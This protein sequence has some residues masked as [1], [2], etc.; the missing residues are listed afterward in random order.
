M[1]EPRNLAAP[2]KSPWVLA[3]ASRPGQC[4]WNLGG[5]EP[6]DSCFLHLSGGGG[7]EASPC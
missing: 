7:E 4:T 1:E 6:C 5:T 2:L 3:S